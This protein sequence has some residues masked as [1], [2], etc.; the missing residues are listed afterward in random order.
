M[1]A[2]VAVLI[3]SIIAFCLA[4]TSF[5]ISVKKKDNDK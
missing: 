4:M 1:T 3:V 2:D 5:I